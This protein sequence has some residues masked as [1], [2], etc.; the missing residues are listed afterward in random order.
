MLQ[1]RRRSQGLCCNHDLCW[2]G[3]E[4]WNKS[5]QCYSQCSVRYAGSYICWLNLKANRA[6]CK[7]H[8]IH[9]S[10]PRLGRPGKDHSEELLQELKEIGERNEVEGK[11]GNGKRKLGLSRIMAKLAE[12]TGAMIGMDI[13]ILNMEKLM[14]QEASLVCSFLGVVFSLA[15]SIRKQHKNNVISGAWAAV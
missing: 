7:D 14:R 8:G 11:F 3:T 5:I 4:T 9:L 10:G 15:L 13:F 2:N 1:N 12:T 6:F